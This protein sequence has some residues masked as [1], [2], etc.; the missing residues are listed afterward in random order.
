MGEKFLL[1]I[2]KAYHNELSKLS[3]QAST[4]YAQ[5][6]RDVFEKVDN[7]LVYPIVQIPYGGFVRTKLERDNIVN[8]VGKIVEKANVY[9]MNFWNSKE[10]EGVEAR[11]YD[12]LKD[13]A[14]K[15]R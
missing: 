15:P 5:N 14:F 2:K 10:A 12:A 9:G 4:S 3:F 11:T 1:F 7:Q 6:H 8:Y 13:I